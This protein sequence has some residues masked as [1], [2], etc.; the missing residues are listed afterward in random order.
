MRRKT[1]VELQRAR[2]ATI[3]RA[4]ASILRAEFL[5]EVLPA[6]LEEFD[7]RLQLGEVADVH[8]DVNRLIEQA[9]AQVQE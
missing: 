8:V 9:V 1:E 5:N 6:A 7:R 4:Q 2:I 3:L